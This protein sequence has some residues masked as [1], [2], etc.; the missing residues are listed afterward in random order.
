M[1]SNLTQYELAGEKWVGDKTCADFIAKFAAAPDSFF[2]KDSLLV[3]DR[4]L[5]AVAVAP[6]E[7]DRRAH[8][9]K[10]KAAGFV[11]RLRALLKTSQA[12]LEL[13]HLIAAK[14]AGLPVP[15]LIFF[16]RR[17]WDA[18]LA[19]GL[20]PG[21]G[22]L[23][24]ILRRNPDALDG[25]LIDAAA[26]LVAQAHEAG[27]LH[28]DLHLGNILRDG[29]GNL[30]LVD[31]HRLEIKSVVA[32]EEAARNLGQLDFSFSRVADKEKRGAVVA[33][34]LNSRRIGMGHDK[35]RR[36]VY[37]ASRAWGARHF[38]S[39]TRRCLRDGENYAVEHARDYTVYRK[40]AFTADPGA[41]VK[42]KARAPAAILK[43]S[44]KT[45]VT[46]LTDASSDNKICVKEFRNRGL[47]PVLERLLRGSRGKRAW[48]NANGLMIRGIAT[49]EPLAYVVTKG[50]EYLLTRYEEDAR[51]L[52][53]YLRA[54]FEKVSDKKT[55]RE[56]WEFMRGLGRTLANLHQ[57]EVFHKDLKANNVLV[58]ERSGV[59][60]LL[61]LDLDRV[62]FDR[63]LPQRETE[64]NLG[65]LNAAIPNF[66][67]ATDRLRAF[68]A[69]TGQNNLTGH[70]K[71]ML[72]RIRDISIARNHLWHPAR[73]TRSQSTVSQER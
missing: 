15:E 57:A 25:A 24:D 58:S 54:C 3:S 53:E 42:A 41:L 1:S 43:E 2:R 11:Q 40:T 37:E 36:A 59:R 26:R 52:D 39:R 51:P 32:D 10:Y 18:Y 71:E 38:R 35:F 34:Y 72:R 6:V 5:R 48:I 8:I 14:K 49:P 30:Y 16:G 13:R 33:A 50:A 61:L 22:P 7:G 28:R 70:H 12:D 4:K 66:I 62:Q 9:K 19:T 55:L 65:C 69:Y 31:M 27:F 64:F 67:T 60:R 46:V 17:G 73:S 20:I 68:K 29:K 56:K 45:R 44:E 23:V 47:G 21:A 63:P